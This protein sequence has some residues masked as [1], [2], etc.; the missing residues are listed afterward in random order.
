M[1]DDPESAYKIGRML[2]FQNQIGG[3]LDLLQGK[4]SDVAT[5][6]DGRAGIALMTSS[7]EGRLVSVP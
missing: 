1:A 7:A 3:F 6:E 5:G 2:A 4:P